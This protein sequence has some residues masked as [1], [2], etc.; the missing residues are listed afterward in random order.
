[1]GSIIAGNTANW[2]EIIVRSLIVYDLSGSAFMLGVVNGSK[3]LPL[4]FVGFL[5]GVLADRVDRRTLL[6]TSQLGSAVIAGALGVLMVTGNIEIWHFVAASV[7]EGVIGAVQQPA[8]QAM[9]PSVVPREHLMNAIALSG[10]VWN[11]SRMVGPAL[12]GFAAALAGP[13]AALFLEGGLYLVGAA[14]VLRVHFRHAE[15]S[16]DAAM[17]GRH[18]GHGGARR[19]REGWL[20]SFR[21]YAYLKTNPVVAWLIVLAL[22]P[23]LFSLANQALAPIFAKEILGMGAGGIGLLLAAPGVGSVAATLIIASVGDFRHKG[24]LILGGVVAMG[25]A[26]MIYGLSTS[27]WLSL[28]I[29]V[30]HGFSMT[31]F[32]SINQTV[33]Q[34][35]TPDEYRGRVMAVYSADR[36]L[37]PVSTLAITLM[38]DVWGAPF[39]VALTGMGCVVVALGVA[40]ASRTL[41]ELD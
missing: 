33:V 10:S 11:I 26:T 16:G 22:V 25:F 21:G 18:G 34:L 39:A 13:A 14:A 23:I 8:R 32:R 35:K 36:G 29:L 9:V 37:H 2:M 7:L 6:M 40:L 3:S 19:E 12:A 1:M 28:G 5:G 17:G 38:T 41:R 4:L 15:V 20:A 24:Y 30:V 31:W 27:V